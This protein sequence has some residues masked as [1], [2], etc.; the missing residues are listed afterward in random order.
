MSELYVQTSCYNGRTIVSDSYFTSPLKIAKPF[1]RENGYTEVM[2]LLA[3]PGMLSGD[4]Y[5]IH[6]E[7]LDNTK[8]II[9]A[10][11]YQKLY[12]CSGGDTVQDVRINVGQNAWLCY[13][14]HPSIPF[15][16]N[17]FTSNMDIRLTRGSKFFFADM[18]ACGRL[19]MGEKHSFA[20]FSSRVCVSVDDKPAFLDHTRLFT[21]EA[22]FDKLGFYEGNACQSLIY[23]YG[24]D[25][26][27]L[28]KC[29]NIEVA[30]SQAREGF[31]VRGLSNSADAAYQFAKKLWE[32]VS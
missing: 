29:D 25:D 14:P 26:V 20:R 5:N 18:L 11:S 2:V 31:A 17:N 23:L 22:D 21:D 7:M 32:L 9:S 27:T 3:G 15:T 6:H 13:L 4:Q 10:Q 8:T 1:Y 30:I 12:N 16:G 24:Y 19:G 28:P